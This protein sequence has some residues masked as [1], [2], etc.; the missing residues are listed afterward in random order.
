MSEEQKRQLEQQLWN[1][2]NTLRGKMDADEFRDYILGFIF[3]KYL[4]EKMHIYGNKLLLVDGIK[5][6]DIN[7]DTKEGKELLDAVKEEALEKLGYF[8]KPSELF[9]EIAKKG[10]SGSDNFILEELTQI[11]N[12]IEQSTMGTESE[13][14]FNKLFEDLDL[15]STKLGRTETAKN[16]LIA[17]VLGHLDKIDFELQNSE[18]DV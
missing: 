9:S 14:D 13:D 1:I 3:Y 16:E 7:E 4:S 11:L 17:K 2:A 12:H 8:L 6:E 18:S 15:T 10:N 5:Y